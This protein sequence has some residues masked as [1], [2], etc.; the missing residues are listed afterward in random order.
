M[1]KLA[2]TKMSS[3]GQI[4][5]PEIIREKLKLKPGSQF[6]VVGENDVVILK[7][8]AAPSVEDFDNLISEARKQALS[9]KLKK[10]DIT[11]A[12]KRVR[13]KK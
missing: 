13:E 7:S 9:S 12:I 8:I 2:T 5:I 3:R 11:S 1:K 4:V 10:S 6:I